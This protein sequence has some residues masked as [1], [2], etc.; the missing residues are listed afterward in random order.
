MLTT[1]EKIN[2]DSKFY[3]HIRNIT[4]KKEKT[5][6]FTK[7]NIGKIDISLKIPIQTLN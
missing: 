1:I 5:C 7:M 6:Q 3:A 2:P 4:L